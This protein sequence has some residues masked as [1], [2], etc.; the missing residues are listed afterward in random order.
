MER[1][2]LFYILLLLGD[3]QSIVTGNLI[4]DKFQLFNNCRYKIK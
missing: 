3:M 4:L 2:E 1:M